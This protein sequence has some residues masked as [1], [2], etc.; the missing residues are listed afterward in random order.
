MTA[1]TLILRSPDAAEALQQGLQQLGAESIV[2]SMVRID[3]QTIS[4]AA[5]H[6]LT[7]TYDG[8]LM[9]SV[10][11]AHYTAQWLQKAAAS[12]A[13][14]RWFAVGPTSAA[15]I[16]EVVQ[17]PVTC[18]AGEHNSEA[19]LKLPELQQV[20]H[21]HWLIIRGN[22]GREILAETLHQRGAQVT[23]VD[24]YRRSAEPFDSNLCQTWVE[25]VDT[26]VVSSA[27][28]LR[29]FLAGVPAQ[30]LRWLQQ[31]TWIVASERLQ[32]LL[33]VAMQA[34]CFVAGSATTSAMLK[35]WQDAVSAPKK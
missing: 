27:E 2:H 21:Q 6:D 7:Q 29:Y 14:T 34:H 23:Y 22:S 9:V 13:P 33:P 4:T 10:N 19:L 31:C 20:K 15:A 25:Q 26:I 11:A 5:L 32:Q 1:S 3:P 12:L 35:A 30:Q 24:V 8:A 16:A 18:A 17:R 28:Q